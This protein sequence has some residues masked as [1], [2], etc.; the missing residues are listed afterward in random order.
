MVRAKNDQQPRLRTPSELLRTAS[1]RRYYQNDWR[2]NVVRKYT[3][4]DTACSE[5]LKASDL[6]DM[7]E[8]QNGDCVYCDVELE[9]GEGVNRRRTPAGLT[10]ERVQNRYPHYRDNCVLACWE[11]NN[12]CLALSTSTNPLS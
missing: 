12:A 4:L 10:I 7:I 9:Y 1:K 2:R 11:C 8:E 5:Y 6:N 3:Q